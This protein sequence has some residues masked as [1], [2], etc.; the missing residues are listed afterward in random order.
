VLSIGVKIGDL[1]DYLERRNGPYF[2]LY[3]GI[4]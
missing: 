3:H 4:S 1:D 2:A